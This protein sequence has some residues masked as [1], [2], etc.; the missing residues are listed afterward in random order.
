M[1]QTLKNNTDF[2]TEIFSDDNSSYSFFLLYQEEKFYMKLT[3]KFNPT[4]WENTFSLNSLVS[5]NKKWGFFEDDYEF[6]SRFVKALEE[7]TVTIQKKMDV[8]KCIQIKI[9]MKTYILPLNVKKGDQSQTIEDM[10]KHIINLEDEIA[11]LKKIVQKGDVP[12]NSFSFI[13]GN[14]NGYYAFSNKNKTV[15]KISGGNGRCG[16]RCD[17]P[18]KISNQMAFSIKIDQNGISDKIKKKWLSESE[19]ERPKK[20]VNMQKA[21]AASLNQNI[22]RQMS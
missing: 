17:P 16:F 2:K 13:T 20:K 5:E 12:F 4:F 6:F 10:V 8:P 21:L 14:N 7:K 18:A 22:P 3:Q 19:S 11:N 15:E 9:D 1:N